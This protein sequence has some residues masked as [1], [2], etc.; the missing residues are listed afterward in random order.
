LEKSPVESFAAV[1]RELRIERQLTQEELGFLSGLQRKHV[2][3][4]E[5]AQKEPSLSTVFRLAR[6]LQI[7][8]G[9]LVEM[10]EEHG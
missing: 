2:S 5:L 9:K 1:L 6:A 8:A 3:A 10:T 7:R 4:L